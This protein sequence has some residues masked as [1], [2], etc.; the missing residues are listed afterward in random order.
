MSDTNKKRMTISVD[1]GT[2]AKLPRINKSLFVEDLLKQHFLLESG[3]KLYN[4]IKSR[5]QKENLLVSHTQ[6]MVNG[7]QTVTPVQDEELQNYRQAY[8]EDGYIFKRENGE[9]LVQR[10]PSREWVSTEVLNY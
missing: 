10:P 1:Y 6:S 9:I 2:Y 8:K 7:H 4:Y 5:L 3:D